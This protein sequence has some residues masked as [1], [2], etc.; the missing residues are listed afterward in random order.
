MKY[1]AA[2]LVFLSTL[3]F[4]AT[5]PITWV[6]PTTYVDNSPLVV[7]D[8]TQN[9]IEYAPCPDG[10]TFPTTGLSSTIVPGNAATGSVTGLAPGT[11]CFRVYTT[12]KAVESLASNVTTKVIVQPAPKPPTGVTAGPQTAY[13]P[14]KRP[15]GLA[16]LAVGTV[17][18]DTPCDKGTGSIAGG[19]TYYAVPAASVSYFGNV[20]PALVVA[21]CG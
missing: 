21:Q 2:L 7:T 1:L 3:A 8:I 16:M 15:D 5:E 12:A 11:W 20:R 6:N 13:T 19:Q 9:R 4:G 14:E 17:P 10:V 18:A